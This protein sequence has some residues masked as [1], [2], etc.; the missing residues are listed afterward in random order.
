M[1][2][3]EPPMSIYGTVPADQVSIYGT[4]PRQYGR[5]A[6]S[7]FAPFAY[8]T[9]R[10]NQLA[11]RPSLEDYFKQDRRNDKSAPE[12][13]SDTSSLKE[14]LSEENM[15]RITRGVTFQN[16]RYSTLPV[17]NTLYVRC[18]VYT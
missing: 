14:K 17:Q 3:T 9:L 12:S 15:A 10:K 6:A 13:E 18:T 1:S 8:A 2:P 5:M 11:S 7:E 4:L 16:L